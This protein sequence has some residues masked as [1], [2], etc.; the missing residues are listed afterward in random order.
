MQKNV[1]QCVIVITYTIKG[2]MISSLKS[3][4]P[5]QMYIADVPTNIAVSVWT[6]SEF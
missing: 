4:M 5:K 3:E 2:A 6:Y 1:S